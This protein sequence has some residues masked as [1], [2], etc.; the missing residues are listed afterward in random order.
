[1]TANALHF[2]CDWQLGFN[3]TARRKGTIGYLLSWSGC[4]GLTLAKDIEVNNPFSSSGQTVVSGPRVTCVGLLE[5]FAFD[6]G[7]DDPIHL[8]ALLSYGNA[9]NLRAKLSSGV[10]T[11]KVKL[12]WYVIGFDEERKSWYE[13][14]LIKGEKVEAVLD[15]ED[16]TLQLR[17]DNKPTAIA[18]HLDV[19]V[20]GVE[21]QVIPAAGKSAQLQF[22]T[23]PITRMVL[24]WSAL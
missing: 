20:H 17:L 18:E 23:G 4:G 22:G 7:K 14:A 24:P 19:M 8:R 6:G 10:A 16:G 5:R 9:A 11:T 2:E 3:V 1:M 21:F 15:T 12:A 13:A